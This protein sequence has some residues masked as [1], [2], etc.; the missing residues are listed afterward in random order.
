MMGKTSTQSKDK[1]NE[2]A[3][4]RY[5]VRIRKDSDLHSDIESFMSKNGTSLNYLVTKLLKDYF[6][7]SDET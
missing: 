7:S 1:Y 6:Q 5:T 4:A 3:Y 2:N